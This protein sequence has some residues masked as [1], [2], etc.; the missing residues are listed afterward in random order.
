MASQWQDEESS[1]QSQNQPQSWSRG[2]QG[3]HGEMIWQNRL[4]K[5]MREAEQNLPDGALTAGYK[6]DPREIVAL[7][8]RAQAS[9]WASFLQYW[10]HFFMASDIHS[11]ELK[12]TFKEHAEDEYEHARLFGERIQQ[13]GG[14]PCDKPE[15][16]ARLTPT[17]TEYNHDLRSMMEADLVGERSTID[18]YDEIIR[19]CGFN[20]NV[21][22]KIFEH[23]IEE[24]AH[25]ADDFATLLFAY[26]GSTG[27]QIESIHEEIENIARA[28]GQ[29]PKLTRRA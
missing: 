23:V 4:Q 26:D 13:L 2:S 3:S 27:K 7:L 11:A 19:T 21:T 12:E 22:R 14:V 8:T 10:H 28:T 25:H 15:D 24:E 9:E 1:G 18:F 6:A 20:D 5:Q 29:Q 17:P 16:I